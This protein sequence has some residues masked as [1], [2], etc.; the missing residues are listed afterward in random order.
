MELIEDFTISEKRKSY[1]SIKGCTK[2]IK[3][4]REGK[5][6]RL[7]VSILSPKLKNGKFVEVSHLFVPSE[8]REDGLLYE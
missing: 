1:R 8:E 6:I 3:I 7:T 5:G 2:E 4:T